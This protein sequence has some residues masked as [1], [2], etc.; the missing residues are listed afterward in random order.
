M[1]E[2]PDLIRNAGL[3]GTAS[4]PRKVLVSGTRSASCGKWLEKC[5]HFILEKVF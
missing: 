4:L 3:G 2:P 5:V 1:L